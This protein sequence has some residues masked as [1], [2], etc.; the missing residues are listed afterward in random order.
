MYE[1]IRGV[2]K[3]ARTRTRMG[4]AIL[5]ECTKTI[6]S[7]HPT[8][9]MLDMAS[10]ILESFLKADSHANMKYVGIEV[11]RNMTGHS[12][13]DVLQEA[14][15][16]CL[17]ASDESLQ[18]KTI[19]LMYRMTNPHNVQLIVGKLLEFLRKTLDPYLAAE[20]VKKIMFLAER[21]STSTQW[22]IDAM[23][24]AILIGGKWLGDD[25]V[26]KMVVVLKGEPKGIDKDTFRIECVNLYMEMAQDSSTIPD[27]LVQILSHVL[28]EYGL[29]NNNISASQ[30]VQVLADQFD[31][32]HEYDATRPKIIDAITKVLAKCKVEPPMDLFERFI[33]SKNVTLRQRCS[34]VLTMCDN[35]SMLDE[36][37]DIVQGNI[38]VIPDINL[39]FMDKYV[40]SSIEQGAKLYCR[41]QEVSKE[42]KQDHTKLKYE[43]YD[44]PIIHSRRV[45]MSDERAVSSLD[46]PNLG[47][48][49]L[50][51]MDEMTTSLRVKANKWNMDGYVEPTQAVD[52]N[53]ILPTWAVPLSSVPKINKPL[54]PQSED[55][56]VQ[57]VDSP[58]IISTGGISA[59]TQLVNST[60]VAHSTKIPSATP[61]TPESP[62]TSPP[63]PTA[64]KTIEKKKKE[65]ESLFKGMQN[66][67]IKKRPTSSQ[68]TPNTPSPT[69]D[70]SP[71][72]EEQDDALPKSYT[73]T[74]AQGVD[75]SKWQDV[76]N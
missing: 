14:V 69:N 28:G 43:Q 67:R 29:L 52:S 61:P 8:G 68:N 74:N 9:G 51:T 70:S 71:S 23:N 31:R 30:L 4:D 63:S 64:K 49:T 24:A 75:K 10:N 41:P 33:N 25:V 53:D 46:S 37:R 12:L 15:M 11:V 34:E 47:I 72:Q 5:Y 22:Y 26:Q 42:E 13:K 27:Y 73:A 6:V 16:D 59:T 56:Y 45:V 3:K 38:E 60:P 7:I 44:A 1:V 21:H 57:M 40:A 18:R 36:Y 66:K 50:T 62:A 35:N 54:S 58:S 55:Q 39:S 48:D 19:R 2:I 17:N 76:S 32:Q 20:L 65:K